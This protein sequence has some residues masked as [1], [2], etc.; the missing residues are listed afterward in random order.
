MIVF[1]VVCRRILIDTGEP[2]VPEYISCLKQAL[3]EFDTAIQ[4][5]LVTHW[6]RDHSGGIVDICE[7]ISN[8]KQKTLSSLRKAMLEK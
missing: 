6:H 2:S 1:H 7:N 3:V 4:E 5:I 8:G